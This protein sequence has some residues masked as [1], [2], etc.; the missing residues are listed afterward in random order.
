VDLRRLEEVQA[1]SRA[2][3]SVSDAPGS[4]TIIPRE[5]LTAFGYPTLADALRGVRGLYVW[6]D[7]SYQS[8]GVRG[9]GRLGSYTNRELV[10]L[11]G[12]P[13]NDDW[14]GSAYIGFDGRT[15][16]ADIERIEVVRGPGSVLYGTNAFS[17]VV[18]LVTRGVDPEKKAGGEVGVSTADYGVMR[19]RVRA[20]ARIGKDAGVWTSVALAH[21]SGRDFFF[22]ELV[23]L[24]STGGYSRGADGFDARTI[25][26]RFYW[27]FFTVQWFANRHD[28]SLPTGEFD[29]LLS[30]PASRQLDERAFVEARADPVLSNLVKL[31]SRLHLNSYRYR[32]DFA[33]AAADGGI[34]HD[35]YDGAWV[36]AEQRVIVT[37]S[38][39]LR[40]TFGG[41]GQYHFLAD[42]KARDDSGIFL[43]DTGE[44]AR[45]Y[46]VGAIYALADVEAS[47]K[48]RL[49]LGM[50]LD[51]Y[52]TFGTSLNPRATFIVRPYERGNT[53]ILAGKAFRAPS[54]YELYYNDGG[55]TQVSSPDLSPE[56]IYSFEIEHSHRFNSTWSGLLAVYANDITN[57]IVTRGDGSDTA[58]L[59]YVNAASP[60]VSVGGDVGFRRE[61]RQGFML[62]ASGG[63]QMTRFVAS[64]S[65]GD[66]LRLKRDGTIRDVSNSPTLQAALKAAAPVVPRTLTIASRLTFEGARYDRYE[67]V[68]E[69]AQGRTSAAV[70]W[71]VVLSGRSER[72]GLGYSLG[73]YNLADWRYSLPVS[74][75]FSQ[76]VIVQNGRTFLASLDVAF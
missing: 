15:D 35:S 23:D 14:V 32:G 38:E 72:L 66:L 63:V 73:V 6:N 31:E 12:H 11:D 13:T 54:T 29:T 61:W 68:T 43:Q 70:I 49:S 42:Q 39:R 51:A 26:G 16:L 71:D 65:A 53:K 3:E 41:E 17:G 20:E 19:G 46:R 60:L 57:L 56:S 7:R 59:H 8:I 44:N 67:L 64:G 74:A 22:P 52:S 30:N 4:V 62:Q 34:E 18:N 55:I 21:G 76:R 24:S 9:V 5:E 45:T 27:K 58:P 47:E 10:L 25:E 2:A 37:P 33:R 48:A 40:L 28:K 75:E 36:G 69:P 50:R 1:A